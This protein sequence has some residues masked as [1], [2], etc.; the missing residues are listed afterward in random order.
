MPTVIPGLMDTD[1]GPL[2]GFSALPPV[3]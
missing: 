1:T 2:N 3:R